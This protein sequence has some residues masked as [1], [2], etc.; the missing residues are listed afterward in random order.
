MLFQEGGHECS[1]GEGKG[2]QRGQDQEGQGVKGRPAAEG[3]EGGAPL[4]LGL[5][6]SALN[7]PAPLPPMAAGGEGACRGQVD[8][9]LSPS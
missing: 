8:Q 5:R 1:A 6:I 4:K 2:A 7:I 3:Q 9:P